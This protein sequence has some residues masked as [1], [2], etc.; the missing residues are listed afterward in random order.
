LPIVNNQG[1]SYNHFDELVP[2]QVAVETV[3]VEKG[4]LIFVLSCY[5]VYGCVEE[6]S[7]T[8]G[9]DYFTVD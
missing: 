6:T 5:I 4:T 1:Y 2:I 9:V 8:L 3:L 7:M